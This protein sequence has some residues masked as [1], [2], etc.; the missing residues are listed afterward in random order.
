[1]S[2][3]YK[4]IFCG[5]ELTTGTPC[6]DRDIE[7]IESYAEDIFNDRSTSFYDFAEEVID[8]TQSMLVE[9]HKNKNWIEKAMPYLRAFKEELEQA[10]IMKLDMSSSLPGQ[11]EMFEL[12]RKE[13][14]D[15]VRELTEMLELET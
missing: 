14:Q 9:R 12:G 10:I 15:Q 4:C 3:G 8:F 13:M 5:N 7:E 2:E 1:M 11:S 6:P